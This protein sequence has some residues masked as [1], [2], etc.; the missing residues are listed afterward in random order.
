MR[1][2]VCLLSGVCLF[3][4]KASNTETAQSRGFWSENLE[5]VMRSAVCLLFSY[6]PLRML[7]MNA[8]SKEVWNRYLESNHI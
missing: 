3:F 8:Q 7:K 5:L 1:S 2:A 4:S 6:K